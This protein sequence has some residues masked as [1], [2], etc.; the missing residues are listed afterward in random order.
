MERKKC[1]S[2]IECLRKREKI[3]FHSHSGN[4]NTI[5]AALFSQRLVEEAQRFEI[6]KLGNKQQEIGEKLQ[7]ASFIYL[8]I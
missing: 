2:D 1:K 5:R 7:V 4:V 6:Q 3:L 8:G